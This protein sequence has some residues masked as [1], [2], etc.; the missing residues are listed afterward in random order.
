MGGGV[1]REKVGGGKSGE[2]RE[3]RKWGTTKHNYSR[4]R[5]MMI[6]NACVVDSIV[7][8]HQRPCQSP[9][10]CDLIHGP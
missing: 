3:K 9:L 5:F 2:K 6:L 4:S 8:V 10:F 7:A 1:N